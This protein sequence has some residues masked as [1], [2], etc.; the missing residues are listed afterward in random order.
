MIS[1]REVVTTL[2]SLALCAG[3]GAALNGCGR[4][5]S[6]STVTIQDNGPAEFQEAVRL[7]EEGQRAQKAGKPD[8]AIKFYQESLSHSQDLYAVWNNLGLLLTEKGDRMQAVTMF[9]RAADLEPEK[10]EPYYNAGLI[11]MDNAQPDKAMDYF[12]KSL[13]RQPRYL[14][15][16]RGAARVGRILVMADKES[17]EW[18]KTALMI[19]KDPVWRRIFEEEKYRIDG[20]LQSESRAGKF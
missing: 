17:L 16:L 14:E 12:K 10:P 3:L 7:A 19:E 11:Y 15:S 8:Q 20:T 1:S 18:M 4:S 9:N 13:A 2:A 6:P 5:N